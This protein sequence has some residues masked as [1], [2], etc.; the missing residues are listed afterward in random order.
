[1]GYTGY[2][3]LRSWV[4]DPHCVRE[5]LLHLQELL[6]ATDICG[7][8]EL[9][10]QQ[11]DIVTG[12]SDWSSSYDEASNPFV[13][14]CYGSSLIVDA[15]TPTADET[16]VLDV[17]IGTGTGVPV[18]RPGVMW[19]GVDLNRD[20]LN[21]LSRRDI[22]V[23]VIQGDALALPFADASFDLLRCGFLLSHLPA[24]EPVLHELARVLRPGGR[25]EIVDIHAHAIYTGAQGIYRT[26]TGGL[27]YVPVFPHLVS[28]HLKAAASSALVVRNVEEIRWPQEA[29]TS[30]GLIARN[31]VKTARPVVQSGEP[32]LL[33]VSSRTTR[34]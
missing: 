12:Y 16:R 27:G 10:A 2:R 13:E 14:L 30:L 23:T 32:A 22:P 31:S 9:G 25:L 7:L 1:M 17:G 20:M 6:G 26:R 29:Q 5:D 24:L 4:T 33:Q 21:V 28:D 19:V 3:I 11:H 34:E 15:W 18:D 8:T